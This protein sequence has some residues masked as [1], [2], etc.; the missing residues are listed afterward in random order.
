[1]AGDRLQLGRA[2]DNDIIIKDNKCSRYHAVLEMR[3][4]GLV[5]KNISTNNR[6][7]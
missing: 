5:I 3:E 7:F 4:H 6:V 2:E 1:M